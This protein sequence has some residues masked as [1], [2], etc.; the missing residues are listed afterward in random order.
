M[1][2]IYKNVLHCRL[3]VPKPLGSCFQAF[4]SALRI[5]F[6][7]ASKGFGA[8]PRQNAFWA[9]MRAFSHKVMYLYKLYFF[10][11]GEVFREEE[12]VWLSKTRIDCIIIRY[13]VAL[14]KKKGTKQSEQTMFRTLKKRCLNRDISD[15]I[16]MLIGQQRLL[17]YRRGYPF[18]SNQCVR[19]CKLRCSVL[20]G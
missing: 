9:D 8:I 1:K 16:L 7:R 15:V 18:H 6:V 4:A 11:F 2:Y 3:F 10:E 13:R 12:Y 5:N 14:K 17:V 19:L 20:A